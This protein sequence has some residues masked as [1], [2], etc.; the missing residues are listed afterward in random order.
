MFQNMSI[1]CTNVLIG[2]LIT[3]LILFE[4]SF[5]SSSH[6][7]FTVNIS[8]GF[9]V[10]FYIYF[11]NRILPALFI[12]TIL[13]R[14]I[15]SILFN[16]FSL[17]VSIS[18]T[19]IYTSFVSVLTFGISYTLKRF[20]CAFP[21]TIEKAVKY[22]LL[23]GIVTTVSSL[24]PASLHMLESQV[25][26][27]SEA[28]VFIK[29]T[30]MGI[31][32]FTTLIIFSSHYDTPIGKH[33]ESIA[34]YIIFLL[35]FNTITFFTFQSSIL[36]NEFIYVT[37]V[38]LVLFM[39]HAFVFNFRLLIL[40]S[41]SYIFSY[42]F[43]LFMYTPSNADSLIFSFN[44][45]L[46]SI[47]V[48][49]ILTKVLIARTEAH[50]G[51]VEASNIKLE[52]MMN[53]TFDLFKIEDFIKN[54]QEGYV[55]TYLSN[56][57]E[58]VLQLFN[59]IDSGICI[60]TEKNSIHIINSKGYKSNSLN[61]LNIKRDKM[62]WNI[63]SP[64]FST[65]PNNFYDLIVDPELKLFMETIPSIKESIRFAVPLG[66]NEFGGFIMDIH[67]GSSEH[68]TPTDHDNI[69]HLQKMLISF[70]D[71]NQLTLKNTN[72]KDDIVL[73]L[74][75]TLELFDQYTGGHSEEVADLSKM[76][77]L[78][79]DIPTENVYNVY[80]A[81]IVHDIGKI[82][83]D[84]SIIN[85][86]T[87]LTIEEYEQ[88]KLHTLD[89]YSILNRSEDL[90]EIAILVRH[91][92]EW[93]NGQGYPDKIKQNDIPLGSQI[94]QVADSVSSMATKRSYSDIKTMNEIKSEL[95]L[96]SSTQFSPVVVKAMIELINEGHVSA[97]YNSR[98]K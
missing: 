26:L 68:F 24:L 18:H 25:S 36:N 27:I 78:K 31:G 76:I 35:V 11:E 65:K 43:F 23:V 5:L 6:I 57:F 22:V 34:S 50:A 47:L 16:D 66:N 13:S 4:M 80:W 30:T 60:R 82:G 79:L 39:V 58:I 67:K 8:I 61:T 69:S 74:I 55:D 45:I 90:K 9:I 32:I 29:P 59:K 53:S 85:K 88:V 75:R 71:K 94:L 97:Y 15:G 89:G 40:S 52:D 1:K 51:N 49:T 42:S 33:K 2:L 41:M 86:Q 63:N 64:V 62:H 37:P 93:W 96:Y 98:R 46:I 92:H 81:G 54:D 77:A 83:V 48:V 17:I 38:L 95:E 70:Y 14:C 21:N 44:V 7:T 56:V 20:D 72:L 73:S 19:L 3:F 12:A 10:G 28:R 87:R 84:P 91:H